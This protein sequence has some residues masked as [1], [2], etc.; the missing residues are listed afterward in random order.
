MVIQLKCLFLEIKATVVYPATEKHIQKYLRQEVHLIRE[1]W[2]DYK[3]ITLPFIQSQSFSIQVW[4]PHS[5]LQALCKTLLSEGFSEAPAGELGV[6][7]SIS[8]LVALSAL[9]CCPLLL[10][11]LGTS[12]SIFAEEHL[13]W[14]CTSVAFPKA[15]WVLVLFTGLL[16]S[17]WVVDEREGHRLCLYSCITAHSSCHSALQYIFRVVKLLLV[18]CY[19]PQAAPA[20]SLFFFFAC[21]SPCLFPFETKGIQVCRGEFMSAFAEGEINQILGLLRLSIKNNSLKLT[22]SLGCLPLLPHLSC[23]LKLQHLLAGERQVCVSPG[24]SLCGIF[25]LCFCS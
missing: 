25:S 16:R 18:V 19:L 3:N 15:S 22:R 10:G 8:P 5:L 9:W 20:F 1:T 24:H 6:F 13:P 21:S 7:C 17:V 2:E 4:L 11:W 12:F 14:S 23:C